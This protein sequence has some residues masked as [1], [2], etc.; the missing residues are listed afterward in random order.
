M[1]E[2]LSGFARFK[3][4]LLGMRAEWKANGFRAVFRRYGWRMVALVFTYYLIRDVTLYIALPWLIA[5]N[6]ISD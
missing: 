6:M 1:P 4:M 5:R 2:T 3:V